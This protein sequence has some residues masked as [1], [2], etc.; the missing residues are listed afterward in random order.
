MGIWSSGL[1]LMDK[2]VLLAG[3]C[4]TLQ[5]ALV[6]CIQLP[7]TALECWVCGKIHQLTD[8]KSCNHVWLA[9]SNES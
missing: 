8:V 2:A 7:V 9:A 6:K 1:D 5:H 4:G 3:V